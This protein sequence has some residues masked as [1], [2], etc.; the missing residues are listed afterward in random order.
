[1][2]DGWREFYKIG[3]RLCDQKPAEP[4]R[5]ETDLAWMYAKQISSTPEAFEAYV[6][7][8]KSLLSPEQ[9]EALRT[10]AN[11]V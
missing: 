3:E 1:M 5:R 8:N 10:E 11:N 2:S 6:K 7:V 9:L 4:T